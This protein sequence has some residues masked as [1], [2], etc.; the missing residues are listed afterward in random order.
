MYSNKC[1]VN[2]LTDLMI[3]HGIN[4]VVMCP[5]SRNTPLLN[6]FNESPNFQCFSVTDERS[7]G[8]YAL[9]LA[10]TPKRKVAVCVTSGSALLNLLPAVAEAFYQR[11]S[12]LVISADRPEAWIDQLDGQTLH[13]PNA[14]K[15]YVSTSVS[16]PEP[17]NSEQ[18]WQCNRL[19]NEALNRFNAP[20]ACPVHINVPISEPLFQFNQAELAPQRK[21]TS[22]FSFAPNQSGMEQVARLLLQAKRPIVV[23]GQGNYTLLNKDHID[24]LNNVA[25]LLTEPLS[26][27]DA[28]SNFDDILSAHFND[29]RL[30]PDLVLYAGES[31]VSKRLKHFLRKQK[32]GN[33]VRFST[34]KN[35]E[36]TFS[37]L[38]LLIECS[39]IE[40]LKALYS[41]CSALQTDGHSMGTDEQLKE[42][43]AYISLWNDLSCKVKAV[44]NDFKPIYSSMQ[45]VALFEQEIAQLQVGCA[46][47]YA[48]S[49]AVRLANIYASHS[50]YCNRGVNGIEGCLSTAVGMSL[51]SS[52]NV[53]CVIG[54]LAF[55]YD[56]NALWNNHLK[57]NMHILLLNNSGGGIFNMLPNISE[58]ASYETFVK[59]HHSA[60]AQGICQQNNVDYMAVHNEEELKRLLPQFVSHCGDR[61]ILLEVFTNQQDDTKALKTYYQAIAQLSTKK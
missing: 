9:G 22:Y 15:P 23:L 12:F 3:Q 44:C 57:G 56:Q 8:F 19:V 60:N 55:F 1:N 18:E 50:I 33:Q 59:A 10:Q 24:F 30:L 6:N 28:L 31:V 25:V 16:L 17:L 40:G 7:A 51:D 26:G 20:A 14:L 46:V 42:K 38:S 45:A 13:Q 48:N 34:Q 39:A 4:T 54:D 5:G 2:I 49:S 37:H 41:T 29:E 53:F 21:I 36:D 61:P 35:I 11:V 58:T 43:K 27:I 32:E 47:H 52:T